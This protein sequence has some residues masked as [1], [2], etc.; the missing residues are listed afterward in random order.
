[1]VLVFIVILVVLTFCL[2]SASRVPSVSS[3]CFLCGMF[4]VSLVAFMLNMVFV[5]FLFDFDRF[6]LAALFYLVS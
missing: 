3:V 6:L 4:T 1:M 5:C 2:P